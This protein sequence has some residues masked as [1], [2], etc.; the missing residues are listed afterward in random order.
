MVDIASKI[1]SRKLL[2]IVD[3]GKHYRLSYPRE[4]SFL[5]T[6]RQRY[7]RLS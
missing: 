7:R 6:L 2:L 1:A 3:Y 5:V 4:P